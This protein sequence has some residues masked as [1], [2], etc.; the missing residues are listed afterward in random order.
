MSFAANIGIF[1]QRVV[2]TASSMFRNTQCKYETITKKG[3]DESEMNL[4]NILFRE[5]MKPSVI[6]RI[7]E[8]L[9]DQKDKRRRFYSASV[10]HAAAWHR[11]AIGLAWGIDKDW[12]TAQKTIAKLE[13]LAVPY[14]ALMMDKS[15]TIITQ[16]CKGRPSL[17]QTEKKSGCMVN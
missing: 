14:Y 4:M 11:D 15:D 16:K 12:S 5:E 6:G 2:L 7:T 8:C 10:Y 17:R 13:A 1:H 3:L 9:C